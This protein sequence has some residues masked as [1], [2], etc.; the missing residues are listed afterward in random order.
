MKEIVIAVDASDAKKL[1]IKPTVSVLQ[2][3]I[4]SD[5]DYDDLKYKVNILARKGLNAII[6]KAN[7]DEGCAS[8]LA[9]A[10]SD[11]LLKEKARHI[12][13]IKRPYTPA[14]DEEIIHVD[15]S[16]DEALNIRRQR[17]AGL[18][19][20]TP[21]QDIQPV[22]VRNHELINYQSKVMAFFQTLPTKLLLNHA[23]EALFQELI[24]NFENQ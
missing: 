10:E 2:R 22:P 1:A 6:D 18:F 19:P 15:D 24:K 16:D 23:Q 3:Y 11:K 21:R 4:E 9:I 8:L 13:G 20:F 5:S 14:I 12:K 17:L 7:T